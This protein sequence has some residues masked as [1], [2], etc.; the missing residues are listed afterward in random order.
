MKKRMLS[1]NL[2]G[3]GLGL[4]AFCAGIGFIYWPAALIAAGVI[5]MGISL[6]GDRTP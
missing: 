6:F 1:S 5:L 2:V 4:C 3:F